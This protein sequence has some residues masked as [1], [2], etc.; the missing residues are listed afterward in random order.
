MDRFPIC[1]TDIKQGWVSILNYNSLYYFKILGEAEHFGKAAQILHIEQ[2]SLSQSIKKLEND[3]GVTLFEKRGRNV[4]LTESGRT[5]H[6]KICTAFDLIG[7]ATLELHSNNNFETIVISSVH[8]HPRSE[9]SKYVTQF[10]NQPGHQNIK[11]SI[12]ER[13]TSESFEALKNNLCHLIVCSGKS[14]FDDFEYI[15]ISKQKVI[16]IVPENHPLA[17]HEQ[18]DIRDVLQY[19]FIYPAPITGMWTL[20]EH[21]FAEVEERPPFALEA[22]SVAFTASL[23]ANNFGIGLSPDS[24]HLDIY[25]VKKINITNEAST[26][27]H[28]LAYSKSKPLSQ[29]A[30]LFKNFIIQEAAAQPLPDTV[31]QPSDFMDMNL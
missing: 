16:L 19:K 2:P 21:L 1:Q 28:Y 11:I 10:L 3:L 29:A 6:K 18:V 24:D 22:E 31:A 25:N 4:S 27:Y 12:F 20:F 13:H 7:D 15:P 23:V 9:F 5:F 8:S 26:F 17:V 14:K 30:E